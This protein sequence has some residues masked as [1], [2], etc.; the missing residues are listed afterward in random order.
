M[1]SLM[2]I[3]IRYERE[4]AP[5]KRGTKAQPPREAPYLDAR[6]SLRLARC[7]EK[8]SELHSSDQLHPLGRASLSARNIW[9]GGTSRWS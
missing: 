4:G 9:F 8:D 6:F 7:V 3:L 2:T 1:H 5:H